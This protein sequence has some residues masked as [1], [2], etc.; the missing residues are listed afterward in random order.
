MCEIGDTYWSY[1]FLSLTLFF[2]WEQSVGV[3]E[4]SSFFIGQNLILAKS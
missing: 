1:N 2:Y 4:L 3:L